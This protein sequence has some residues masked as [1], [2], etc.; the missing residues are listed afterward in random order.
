[1]GNFAAYFPCIFAPVLE[2]RQD[3]LE[4]RVSNLELLM[5]QRRSQAGGLGRGGPARSLREP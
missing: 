5:S 1:M 2:E 3:E 4:E